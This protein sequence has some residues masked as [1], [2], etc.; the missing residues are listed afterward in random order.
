M[1]SEKRMF[2]M[3]VFYMALAIHQSQSM[4]WGCLYER[5]YFVPENATTMN[6]TDCEMEAMSENAPNVTMTDFR[7]DQEF[8]NDIGVGNEFR[9]CEIIVARSYRVIP[10]GTETSY[11]FVSG[12]VEPIVRAKIEV[13]ADED[14][15]EDLFPRLADNL[16]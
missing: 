1:F 14:R 11:N 5:S 9:L 12:T 6:D 2:I 15:M 4:W 8:L 7:K 13:G 10:A 3:G 16:E